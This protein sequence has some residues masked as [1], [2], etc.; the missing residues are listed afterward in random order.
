VQANQPA[1]YVPQYLKS[2]GVDVIPVPVYFPEVTEIL[3]ERVYRKLADIPKS[4][5]DVVVNVFRRPKD[6]AQ[7]LDDIVLMKPKAVWLQ[8]GISDP[9]FEEAVARA[10][11]QVVSDRCLLVDHQSATA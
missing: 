4:P 7:H 3:G 9:D 10:G 11:I 8:S 5:V 2:V 1:Y 6:L